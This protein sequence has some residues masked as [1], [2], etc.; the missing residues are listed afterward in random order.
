MKNNKLIKTVIAKKGRGI[1]NTGNK[2]MKATE[3]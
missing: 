2:C 3:T 1:E